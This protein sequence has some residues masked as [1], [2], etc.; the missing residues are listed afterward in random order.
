MQV[1]RKLMKSQAK[2][3]KSELS[4]KLNNAFYSI[5]DDIRQK[6]TAELMEELDWSLRTLYYRLDGFAPVKRIEKQAISS[7]FQKHG[8][9]VFN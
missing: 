7:V 1:K 4:E 5:P 2:E 9:E 6:I 8:F 3:V